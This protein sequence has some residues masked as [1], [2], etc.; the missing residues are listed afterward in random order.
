MRRDKLRDASSFLLTQLSE[1]SNFARENQKC[2]RK[3]VGCCTVRLE[4]DM[5]TTFSMTHNGPSKRDVS[6]AGGCTNEVGNCGCGH[7]EPRAIMQTLKS[8]IWRINEPKVI[9]V[10]TYSPC[11]NC[12]NIIIDSGIVQ[13]VVRDILTEHDVRGE[14]FLKQAGIKCIT[15]SELEGFI[16][17]SQDKGIQYDT[18]KEWISSDRIYCRTTKLQFCKRSVL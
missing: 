17:E 14:E 12:A 3:S 16:T 2:L 7:T 8:R 5:F 15:R 1:V 11:T 9:I 10:C 6:G 18:I 13:G 4:D